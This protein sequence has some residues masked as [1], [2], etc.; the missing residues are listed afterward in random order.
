MDVHEATEQ[1]YKNGYDKGYK[2]G[3]GMKKRHDKA[4]NSD[5]FLHIRAFNT[6]VHGVVGTE[7]KLTLK[8]KIRVLFGKGIALYIGD[9]FK[10]R[11]E[12][13]GK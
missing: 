3:R 4:E 9:V 11:G 10:E 7:I 12:K 8:E 1:A 13:D 2:D 5:G 6:Y